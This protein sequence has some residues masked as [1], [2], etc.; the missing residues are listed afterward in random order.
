MLWRKPIS[1]NWLETVR[2]NGFSL[3][4]AQTGIP[5]RYGRSFSRLTAR[6]RRH[7]CTENLRFSFNVMYNAFKRLSRSYSASER[8]NL[9]HDTAVRVYR[10]EA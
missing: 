8:A 1:C 10:I 7:A 4:R 2:G 3:I 6:R 9:L 5:W